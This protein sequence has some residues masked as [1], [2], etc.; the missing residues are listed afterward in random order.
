MFKFARR[1]TFLIDP[2]GVVA[3]VYLGVD[4]T[5]NAAH[6]ARDLKELVRS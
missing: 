2:R 3:K 5:R 6:V 1:N 4:P